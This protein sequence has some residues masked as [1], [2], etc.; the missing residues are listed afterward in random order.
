MKDLTCS[1]EPYLLV[2]SGHTLKALRKGEA[3]GASFA[4][5][6]PI[7]YTKAHPDIL[8]SNLWGGTD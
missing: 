1:P 7:K 6:S 4:V 8:I 3:L 2:I 5:L